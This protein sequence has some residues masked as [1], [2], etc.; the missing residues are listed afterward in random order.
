[1]IEDLF[2]KG[3]LKVQEQ[4]IKLHRR[5][6]HDTSIEAA[7]AIAPKLNEIQQQVLAFARNQ[8]DGFTDVDLN[9][10][11]NCTGS[12]FRTRRAELVAK[13]LIIN[14]WKRE[15]IHGRSHIVWILKDYL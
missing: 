8:P 13:G 5:H 2:V 14:S 15:R 6:D 12:T 4:S 3:L 11:F 10:F 9:K 7:I 1:M